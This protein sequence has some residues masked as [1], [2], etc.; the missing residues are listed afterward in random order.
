MWAIEYGYT[1]GETKPVLD[2]VAESELQYAT[3]EDTYGPDPLARRYDFSADPLDYAQTQMKLARYHRER[4][5]EKFV[6]PGESWARAREGYEMTFYM[7]VRSLSMMANWLGGAYIRRDKKGDKDARP[8]IEVVPSDQQRQAFRFVV[9]NAFTDNAFGLTPEILRHMGTDQWLDG[10]FFVLADATWPVHDRIMGIQSSVLTMLM[11]PST[12]T[13]VYDNEFRVDSDK[14]AVTLP[15]IF[16][17]I[18]GAIWSE[19]EDHPEQKFTD[20]QPWISSLRRNLQREHLDRLIDL[21]MP[22]AAYDAAA[23]PIANLATMELR[24]I[25]KK[26]EHGLEHR[27]TIDPYSMAHLSEADLRIEKALEAQYIYNADDIGGGGYG[28]II[29]FGE[30]GK[31]PPSDR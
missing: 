31:A 1:F 14:D 10:D 24:G 8:P 15:E 9:E 30:D 20:R 18:S 13:G 21:S 2:R 16:S 26:V 3:D 17:T 11:N 27:G 6:E 22:G 7:Q 25:K 29:F 28:S 12:L 4:L 19:L 5:V 23:R